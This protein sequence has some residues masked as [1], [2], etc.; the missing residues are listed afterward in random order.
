MV[1]D[2]PSNPVNGQTYDNFYWD[3]STGVWRNNGSKNALSS[4][5]TSLEATPSGLVPVIPTSVSVGSGS[6]SVSS[7]GIV[8]FTN[9]GNVG[10]NGCFTSAYKNYRVVFRLTGT[11]VWVD[12]CYRS[13]ATG[14]DATDSTYYYAGS[15]QRND[16]NGFGGSYN[17]T[18]ATTAR[19]GAVSTGSTGIGHGVYDIFAPQA[20]EWTSG[21]G[22]VWGYQGS[23]AWHQVAFTHANAGS[24]D[25]FDF[26][27][28]AGTFSGTLQ[29]YGYRN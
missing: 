7:T 27:P 22:V 1:L 13:R 11:S 21:S 24:F 29:I 9:A 23:F 26:F 6:A 25:G 18:A 28:S 19:L 20:A 5:L 12:C 14:T 8:T 10:I 2:F 3:A 15:Y 4:R 17:G 16:V